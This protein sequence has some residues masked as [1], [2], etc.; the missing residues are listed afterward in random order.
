MR[1]ALL[2]ALA[3]LIPIFAVADQRTLVYGEWGTPK[4]CAREPIKPGGT[5]LAE[6]YLIT[7]EWLRHGSVWCQLNWFPVEE[8]EGGVFTGANARCGEDT[9]RSYMLGMNLSEGMLT[10][11]WDIFRSTGP[12]MRCEQ[13]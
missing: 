8:R 9:L 11:R 4:Q 2:V 10:L 13:R 3:G 1:C 6:P 7:D 12:L 5:V